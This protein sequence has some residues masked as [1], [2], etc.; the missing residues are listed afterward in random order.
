MLQKVRPIA[1]LLVTLCFVLPG[2]FAQQHA[3]QYDVADIEYGAQ[4]FSQRC[5]VCHGVDG[6][7]MPQA[8]LRSGTF[9]NAGSDRELMGVIR[10]GVAG[11]A[12]APTGYADAEITALIAYLRNITTWDSS[13]SGALLG[14]AARGR[15]LFEGRGEC[16]EC[17]RVGPAGPA[18]AP[19]LADVGARRTAAALR[20][21][22]LEPDAGLLPINRPVRAVTADGRVIE[23]R[24]LNEDTFTVQLV[25]TDERLVSLDKASLQEYSIGLES[26]HPDYS[27]V[28]D[29]QEIADL[30]AYLL[31]LKGSVR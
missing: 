26:A 30:L 24:R 14:D 10:D 21:T 6:D 7:L 15:R 3:G 1:A 8:N 16:L 9:R 18:Y 4:L 28:F 27:T 20:R 29:E 13:A 11:T 19:P 2:A 22:L 23:G 17:H 31:S 5:V 12:M 25:T